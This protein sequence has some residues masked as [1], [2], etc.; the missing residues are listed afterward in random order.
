[1]RC[2]S[3]IVPGRRPRLRT[4]STKPASAVRCEAARGRDAE[5]EPAGITNSLTIEG[6]WATTPQYAGHGGLPKIAAVAAGGAN[7]ADL[8]AG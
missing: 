5:P 4:S 8:R 7:A 6:K 2:S 1:M 3:R